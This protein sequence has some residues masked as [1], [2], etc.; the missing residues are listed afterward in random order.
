MEIAEIIVYGDSTSLPRPTD[1][2]FLANTWY[3][4]ILSHSKFQ[5]SLENRS[6]GG[7]G[8]FNVHRKILNDSHYLFPK[9]DLTNNSKLVILNI[10]VVD[11]AVHPITYK[12][13]IVSKV[14]FFGKYLWYVLSKILNPSRAFIQNI[15]SYR[16]TNPDTFARIFTKIIRFLLERNCKVCVILTPIPHLNLDLRSP[17]FRKNVAK[18]NEIKRSIVDKFP[19][20]LL[21]SVDEFKDSHYVSEHDGHHYSQLGHEYIFE[22]IR[23]VVNINIK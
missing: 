16:T 13:K 18:Y 11:A 3:W 23:S 9:N 1:Q 10:G 2:V 6:E 17:G 5:L 8:I 15:W 12:L 20:V 7:I 19:N 22:T 21:V 14:P 4:R